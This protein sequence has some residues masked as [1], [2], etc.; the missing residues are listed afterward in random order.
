MGVSDAVQFIS[1]AV[2]L[3]LAVTIDSVVRR[4]AA[5]GL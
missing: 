2:V 3:I 5:T 4:R 1:T